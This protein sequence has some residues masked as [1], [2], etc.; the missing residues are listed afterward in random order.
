MSQHQEQVFRGHI[1]LADIKT[2]TYLPVH[3]PE[4]ALRIDVAYQFD[5]ADN[6]L[7]IGIFDE[8]GI[9]FL[10]AGFRGWSGSA[11]RRFYITPDSATPGYTRGPILPGTWHVYLGLYDISKDGCDYQVTVKIAFGPTEETVAKSPSDIPL[12]VEPGTSKRSETGWYKGD[13]HCHT[14]HSDGD[15][16]PEAVVRHAESFGLDFLAITD[17]NNQTQHA[18]L[19]S[20]ATSIILIPGYEVTTYHGHW[21]IW[22][23]NS[24]IDF[25]IRTEADMRAAMQ[26][27]RETGYLVSCNHPR[28]YGPPWEFPEVDDFDC[29]EVWNGP[30]V[31]FNAQS[32]AYWES[33]LREGERLVAVGGSDTHFLMRP[34]IAQLGV[35]TTWIHCRE[36]PTAEALLAGLRAGHAFISDAH[37]GPQLYLRSGNAMMGDTVQRPDSGRLS[38]QVRTVKSAGLW[39]EIHGAGGFLVKEEILDGDSLFELEIPVDSTPYIRAQLLEKDTNPGTMRAL[40]NPIYIE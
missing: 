1:K 28:P 12:S 35:P 32:L 25:R 29:V 39:L 30:W 7:D 4:D 36:Q 24:W 8:R 18:E 27:A 37:D 17:H 20:V 14:F 21:N 31:L 11:R 33:R 26:R 5:A 34:H 10:N 9:E 40:S 2:H 22:G 19:K 6:V 13:L 3:V 16:S 38:V 15:S 23:L